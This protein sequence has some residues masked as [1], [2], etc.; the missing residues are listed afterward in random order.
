MKEDFEGTYRRLQAWASSA[1]A[2]GWL[3]PADLEPL[4]QVERQ[5]AEAIFAQ[6]SE[7]PLIVAFFGGTGVGKSSLLNRLAGEGIA[8]V[9]VQRPTSQEV[10]LY[11]HQDYQLGEFP[12]ELP[13]DETRIAYH[14]DDSRRLI[15]WLDMP[16]IDSVEQRHRAL[17]QAWLPYIDWLVYVVSPE[18]YQDDLGWRFLQQRADR[19]SWLFIMNHSDE[20]V[21]EQV[22]DLRGRLLEEG[23]SDPIILRTSCRAGARE[24]EF[25]RLEQ[26]INR[27]IEEYGLEVLQRLGLQAR[28]VELRQLAAGFLEKLEGYDLEGLE[29]HW[30]PALEEG[31]DGIGEELL[32]NARQA[33]KQL[34]AAAGTPWYRPD[35]PEPAID[36]PK[37]AE[38]IWNDR[39][40]TRVQDLVTGMENLL[41][42][43]G[44]PAEPF[45]PPLRQFAD[46]ARSRMVEEAE[47]GL[48]Q[49]LERPG[50][51]LRRGAYRLC[52]WL[53]WVLPLGAAGWAAWQLVAGFY[54]GAEGRAEFLGVNFAIHTL[55]LVGL[56]WFVPWLLQRKLRPSAAGSA[57]RG[58]RRGIERGIDRLEER[59][60]AVLGQV[61]GEWAR[62]LESLRALQ[63]GLGAGDAGNSE[64][65]GAGVLTSVARQRADSGD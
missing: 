42:R 21:P 52:S 27:A 26:I 5:Q 2:A 54:A 14:Q 34:P 24:D 60:K 45:A 19:H 37:L 61:R 43:Q 63:A 11:L 17:V 33:V 59:G 15:A 38:A 35:R 23:F 44:V 32:Q 65:A 56:A 49:A 29:R 8:R 13:L 48:A 62:Q 47:K 46:T 4:E 36:A 20:G 22:D 30:K 7:R 41:R 39:I 3:S 9:G 58:L 31:L 28:L 57:E 1:A 53:S 16:D 6:A 64:E 25:A 12:A 55:L 18:R 51:A 50:G 40:A 10:T